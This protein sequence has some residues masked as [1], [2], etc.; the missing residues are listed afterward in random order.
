M[1]DPPRR[2]PELVVLSGEPFNAETPLHLL[3]GTITP[4]EIHYVRSHFAV[5]AYDGPLIVDGLVGREL[6]LS[7]NELRAM[8]HV[9]AAVT[10]ECAG[11]G[12]AFLDPPAPG[13]QWRLGAVGTAE[14]A[15]VPLR[16]VLE[17]AEVGAAAT[18]LVF[19]GADRGKH[20]DEGRQIAFER[21]L[22]VDE[23]L[24]GGALLAYS[25]NGDPLSPDHGAP[26]RL[27]VPGAYG[28][29]SVKWLA[30]ITA[31]A[32]PFEGFYQRDRYVIEGRPLGPMAVRA[33]IVAPADG[34][35]LAAGR[36]RVRGYC[37]SGSDPVAGV[38]VSCAGIWRE[39][40]LGETPSL[41]A[42]SEWRLSWDARPGEATLVARART[43][44]G[45]R[46][47]LEQRRNALGYANNGAR[48]VRVTVL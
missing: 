9:S 30:R 37:W 31:I 1:I 27:V 12:R 5:P 33:V 43:A 10:L 44:G 14:W 15:G 35:Q 6:A 3:S 26:L 16:D 38:E 17:R 41:H 18:E 47:P 11:N 13:E 39:A 24:R 34:E 7:M 40:Q 2:S 46:Q 23:A 20:P 28:M 4:A 19:V 21:S 29:A 45:A 42:W 36:I 8:P 32:E 48:P 25:M 22:T